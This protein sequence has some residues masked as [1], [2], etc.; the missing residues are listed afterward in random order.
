MVEDTQGRV[1]VNQRPAGAD[2]M[3]GYWEFPGGKLEPGEGSWQA[4]VRE[5]NEELAIDVA[6][7]HELMLLEHCYVR[8]RVQLEIWRVTEYRGS[9]TPQ[10]GQRI[11]WCD[12]AGLARLQLLPADGPIVEK[13]MELAEAQ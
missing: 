1:L 7:G 6:S 2:F 4:L 11:E 3:P 10:E 13:L 8:R 5:L 12:I 9:P